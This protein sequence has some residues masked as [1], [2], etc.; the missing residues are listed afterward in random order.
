MISGDTPARWQR[1]AGLAF[2]RPS[3]RQLLAWPL[4]ALLGATMAWT[5]TDARADRERAAL[6]DIGMTDASALAAAYAQQLQRSVEQIDQLTLNLRYYWGNSGGR[7]RLEDQQREGL[8]PTD[9]LLYATIAGRTGLVLTS[10][11]ARR[12]QRALG[13][14][15]YFIAHRESADTGLHISQPS[16]G[17]GS[18][19]VVV[20][21]SRRINT[22]SGG[23]GGL[24]MLSV[25]PS[26]LATFNDQATLG[27]RGFL[28]VRSQEGKL[29]AT[30]MGDALREQPTV[31]I[32][33]RRC[34][35][36]SLEAPG[37]TRPASSTV[38]P[39]SLPGM[40]CLATPWWPWR[41]WRRMKYSRHWTRGCAA[42]SSPR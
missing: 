37:M 36:T 4:A 31:Y 28:S 2:L 35:R 9:G 23:F 27:Q 16:I 7:L 15:D 12:Q 34:S 19:K 10:T 17:R 24:V 42:T 18:G 6:L 30:K 40:A 25:E 22:P 11:I 13:D 41:G 3:L 8:Y 32:E 39:G 33:P 38:M 29:F 5:L 21:F 1:L 20:R 14:S 26:Y